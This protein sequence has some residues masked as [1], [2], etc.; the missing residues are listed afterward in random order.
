M[1]TVLFVAAAASAVVAS[2]DAGFLGF[3]ASSRTAGAFTVIDVFAGVQNASDKFLNVYNTASNGLFVQ[4]AGNATKTWKPDT[5]TY[6]STRSSSDDSF[7]TAGGTNF[8]TPGGEFYASSYSQGDPNFTGTSWNGTPFSAAATTIPALA[9][10]YTTDPTSADNNAESLAG[11]VGRTNG[12]GA[13]GA[14]FGIWCAHLVL[15]GNQV[16][17]TDFTFSAF[18]SIKDGVS[19]AVSQ[20]SSSFAAVP[21]PGALALLGLAG[22]AAR[23]RR[24]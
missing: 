3:V 15:T 20:A 21:A 1:K 19:G 2:A 5:A 11:L 4:R 13:A 14:N 8:G 7:M 23:R 6:L 17:G 12:T 22:F 16:I 9:G 24:A 18:A 10:W